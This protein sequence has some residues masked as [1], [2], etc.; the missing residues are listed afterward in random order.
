[1]PIQQSTLYKYCSVCDREFS[2]RSAYL[3][4]MRRFHQE[5]YPTTSNNDNLLEVKIH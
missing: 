5:I 4:H 3:R 2:H 1:M